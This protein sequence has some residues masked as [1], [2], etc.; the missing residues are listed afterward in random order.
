[1]GRIDEPWARRSGGVERKRVQAK[2]EE[3]GVEVRI[4]DPEARRARRPL[5][6]DRRP[7]LHVARGA[8]GNRNRNLRNARSSLLTFPT[9]RIGVST[10]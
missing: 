6:R 5:H 3:Q 8:H 7:R 9:S 10:R 4:A 2:L 1:M